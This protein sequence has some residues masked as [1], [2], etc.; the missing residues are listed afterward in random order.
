MTL[1]SMYDFAERQGYE[2]DHRMMVKARSISTQF[3]D[4]SCGICMDPTRFETEWDELEQLAHEIGHC[5][6]LAFYT[7]YTPFETVGRMEN[8]AWKWAIKK[9]VPEDE[10]R[11]LC[12]QNRN[13]DEMC[14][15]FRVS[16]GFLQRAVKYYQNESI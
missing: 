6:R 8:K 4:G 12:K 15:Y 1:E 2:V 10:L 16:A 11:E 7:R 5:E 3:P 13:I 9:L 14:D